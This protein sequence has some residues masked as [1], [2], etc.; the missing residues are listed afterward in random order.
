MK[1]N[2]LRYR[3]RGYF[4]IILQ[5]SEK[6]FKTLNKLI[7]LPCF[8]TILGLQS[9]IVVFLHGKI[10]QIKLGTYNWTH[11]IKKKFRYIQLDT[12][13]LTH[14]LWHIQLNTKLDTYLKTQNMILAIYVRN[15]SYT[16]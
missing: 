11:R 8:R 5:W 4:C 14:K 16:V 12:Q 3:I 10:R 7:F 2:L 13:N 15:L 1:L 9:I 6:L